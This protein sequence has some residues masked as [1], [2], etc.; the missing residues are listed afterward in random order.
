MSTR[1]S[2][3][4][5]NEQFKRFKRAGTFFGISTKEHHYNLVI[6]QGLLEFLEKNNAFKEWNETNNIKKR[7][8][9][10]FQ[11]PPLK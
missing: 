7:S 5:N 4:L 6:I 8:E 3:N 9:S 10:T 1:I 2:C 11:P